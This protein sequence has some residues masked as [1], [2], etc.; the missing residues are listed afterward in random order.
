MSI[1]LK[2][3][4]YFGLSGLVAGLCVA[5]LATLFLEGLF[6]DFPLLAFPIAGG[7]IAAL[8]SAFSEP[9][10]VTRARGVS[11]SLIALVVG[12]IVVGLLASAN[13]GALLTS[14]LPGVIYAFIIY[15]V[16]FFGLPAAIAG[17]IAGALFQAHT[18]QSNKGP[19]SQAGKL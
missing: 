16:L 9:K 5:I 2:L 15:G 8:V 7:G 11:I 14:E 4:L 12:C 3:V 1:K 17:A 19:A 6:S 10:K 13:A 18:N